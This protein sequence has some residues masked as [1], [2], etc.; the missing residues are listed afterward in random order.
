MV[1]FVGGSKEF[2]LLVCKG[3]KKIMLIDYINTKPEAKKFKTELTKEKGTFGDA[4]EQV[5]KKDFEKMIESVNSVSVTEFLKNSQ[6]HL[7]VFNL[8]DGTILTT[9]ARFE[10]I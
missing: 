1:K 4:M 7:I 6:K 3:S 2:V 9:G 10:T 5:S 8:G